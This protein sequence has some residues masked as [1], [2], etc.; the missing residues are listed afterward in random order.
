MF[1]FFKDEGVGGADIYIDLGTENTLIAKRGEGIVLNEP[2]LIAYTESRPGQKKIIAIGS[3]AKLKGSQS[4]GNVITTRPLKD[5]VIADI[6]TTE[7][8]LKYF[9]KRTGSVGF[10]KRPK[11]VVS[12]PYGVTEVEKR[13]AIRAGKAAGAKEVILIDEPMAA[14]VGAG[15]PID[16]AQGSMVVDIG[17]GTTEVAVIALSDIVYCQSVKSGGH[18]FDQSILDYLRKVKRLIISDI[19]AE[20][21]KISL[22]TAVPKKDIRSS[23][24]KG[25]NADTGL[26]QT[27][28]ITSEDIGNA[29]DEPIGEIIHAITQALASTPPELVSDLIES[30]IVLTGGGA[31]IRDLDL[32]LRNEVR[33][34]VRQAEDPLRA[35]VRG[36][37]KLLSLPELL[38]K[39]QLE[40]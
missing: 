24:I 9:L 20:E 3:E 2:S 30:G 19:M 7:A 17:G 11:L 6:E 15:L 39:I 18:R 33:L 40:V 31:L 34:P 13:A 1:S 27:M 26:L 14:A 32:R 21:L 25:R 22:G 12:L 37:E 4:A 23:E 10:M 8:M 16:A 29:L 36:G 38:E 28:E 5:G 35:L